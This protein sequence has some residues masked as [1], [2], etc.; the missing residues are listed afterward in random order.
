MLSGNKVG[1][2]TGH[3]HLELHDVPS[4][5][6]R[7]EGTGGISQPQEPE[8]LRDQ[9]P[10]IAPEKQ[11]WARAPER[12]RKKKT[13]KLWGRGWPGRATS[14]QVQVPW[15]QRWKTAQKLARS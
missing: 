5:G 3:Q 15:S 13:V 6:C 8:G 9:A 2:D 14:Y 10:R 4:G 1:R 12:R 7:V 11:L